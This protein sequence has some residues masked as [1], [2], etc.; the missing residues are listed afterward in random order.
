MKSFSFKIVQNPIL[1]PKGSVHEQG[2]KVGLEIMK[3]IKNDE[4][5]PNGVKGSEV[6]VASA[7][8][9]NKTEFTERLK[10]KAIWYP[11]TSVRNE[12]D[13]HDKTESPQKHNV[14]EIL[15][16]VI[17]NEDVTLANHLSKNGPDHGYNLAYTSLLLDQHTLAMR[18]GWY[19]QFFYRYPKPI[20]PDQE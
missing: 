4:G 9:R 12:K 3:A 1:G 7:R 5:D 17:F 10:E 19:R 6:I 2:I 15:E 16:P 11:N 20:L 14:S 18:H 8:H 13:S